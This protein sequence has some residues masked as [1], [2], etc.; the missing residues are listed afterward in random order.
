MAAAASSAR[1]HPPTSASR[2]QQRIRMIRQ[3]CSTFTQHLPAVENTWRPRWEDEDYETYRHRIVDKGDGDL[4]LGMQL[5]ERALQRRTGALLQMAEGPAL[6]AHVEALSDQA[7]ALQLERQYIPPQIFDI[8][9]AAAPRLRVGAC[10]RC[11]CVWA[12]PLASAAAAGPAPPAAPNLCD[13]CQAVDQLTAAWAPQ[14]PTKAVKAAK[15][16]RRKKKKRA[17]P[18]APT[19]ADIHQL[20]QDQPQLRQKILGQA[21]L[22]QAHM[23]ESCAWQSPFEDPYLRWPEEIQG[24]SS[25]L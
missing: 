13:I 15:K 4:F 2:Q 9:P 11:R 10:A 20:M 17:L 7:D 1:A 25:E 19:H 24:A 14:M 23:H 22:A 18:V 6:R 16:K 12:Q 5:L 3:C 21:S 8:D